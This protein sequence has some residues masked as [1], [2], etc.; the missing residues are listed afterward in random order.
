M[1]ELVFAGLVV[2]LSFLWLGWAIGRGDKDMALSLKCLYFIVGVCFL[3]AFGWQSAQVFSNGSPINRISPGVYKVGFVYQAGENV[4]LGIE[5]PIYGKEKEG[6]RLYL[7]QLPEKDFA[8][9]IRT[10]A[11]KLEALEAI[12]LTN[13]SGTFNRYELK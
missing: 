4:N 1:V 10:G 12:R 3:V 8:G 7:Y 11:K 5:K 13:G 6:D 9:E 2:A